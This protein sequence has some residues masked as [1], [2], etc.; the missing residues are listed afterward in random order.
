M[1]NAENSNY[2]DLNLLKF[3]MA[4]ALY[5]I[6]I[7][8]I[9]LILFYGINVARTIDGP[10]KIFK[11]TLVSFYIYTISIHAFHLYRKSSS[12]N[13]NNSRHGDNNLTSMA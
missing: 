1:M 9:S 4:T 7:I 5:L 11:Y 8:G 12:N 6:R 10:P 13:D 2:N 3:N